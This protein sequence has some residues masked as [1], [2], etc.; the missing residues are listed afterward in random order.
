M[1]VVAEVLQQAI[2]ERVVRSRQLFTESLILQRGLEEIV[3]DVNDNNQEM[4]DLLDALEIEIDYLER[5][6]EG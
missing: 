6:N 4:E 3:E 2:D 1:S 5:A